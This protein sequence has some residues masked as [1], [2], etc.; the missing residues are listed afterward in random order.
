MAFRSV[1]TIDDPKPRGMTVSAKVNANFSPKRHHL[2]LRVGSR[3]G[4]PESVRVE[5]GTGEDLGGLKILKG[6]TLR[7]S[8]HDSGK[9]DLKHHLKLYGV[10][11]RDGISTPFIQ[12]SYTKLGEGEYYIDLPS[13]IVRA[14]KK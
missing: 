2:E 5:L 8:R 11:K 14:L 3:M 13:D 10:I 9:G 1:T 12:C 6:D 4:I 7:I